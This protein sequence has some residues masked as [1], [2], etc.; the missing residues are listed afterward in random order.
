MNMRQYRMP[1]GAGLGLLAVL[2]LLVFALVFVPARMAGESF[3]R[4]G[5][6]PMLGLVVLFA[7]L[8][9]RTSRLTIHTSPHLVAEPV[10]PPMPTLLSRMGDMAPQVEHTGELV[11]QRIA[12]SVGGC[13]VPLAMCVLFALRLPA[14]TEVWAWVAGAV[15]VVAV[16]CFASLKPWLGRGLRVPVFIPPAATLVACLVLQ[17]KDFAPQAAYIAAVAGTL[18]GTGVAPLL[19]PRIRNRLD[20]PCIVIGGPGVFGGLFI[21]SIVAGLFS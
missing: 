7:M 8:L 21:A 4:L 19:L 1:P 10:A 20:A 14:E 18:L 11:R 5:L 13:L 15:L 16:V 2:A 9:W 12:L 3:E 17:G 6:S